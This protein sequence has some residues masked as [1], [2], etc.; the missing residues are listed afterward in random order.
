[1]V[2]DLLLVDSS[3]WIDHLRGRAPTA[4]RRLATA[5]GD[6]LRTQV[7]MCEPV[8]MELLAGASSAQLGPVSALVDGLPGL[9]VDPHI[10]FRSAAELSRS[11]RLVGRTVRSSLD[12]LIAAVAL[13][14]DA[15]VVHRDRDFD[16]L[17]EISPLRAERWD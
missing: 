11:A 14:H 15:V 12:C 2:S 9:D 4:S 17:S 10:D 3:L 7:R 5:I 1:V 13:R 6:G 16:V 8:A